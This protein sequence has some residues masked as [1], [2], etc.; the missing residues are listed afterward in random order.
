MA[1]R[2]IYALSVHRLTTHDINT[3]V[4][5]TAQ[6]FCLVFWQKK[7]LFSINSQE[8]LRCLHIPRRSKLAVGILAALKLLGDK[9]QLVPYNSKYAEIILELVYQKP[10]AKVLTQGELYSVITVSQ[11]FIY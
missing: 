11:L 1:L 9:Q 5:V 3:P 7:T 10:P 8:T 6:R 4:G 2:I